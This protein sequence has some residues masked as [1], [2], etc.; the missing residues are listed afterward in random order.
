M[1]DDRRP[2]FIS[3]S[4][5]T[6]IH[7]GDWARWRLP[8]IILK[9]VLL[10]LIVSVLVLQ[11]LWR[12]VHAFEIFGPVYITEAGIEIGL[13]AVFI[14][15]LL[16]NT[17]I[18]PL[19][20]RWHTLRDYSPVILAISIG[21]G[22][23]IG[24]LLCFKF[25]EST[26]GRFLQ[27]VEL[28]MLILFVLVSAFYKMPVR[29]SVVA[30]LVRRR[31][32]AA[33]FRDVEASA[34]G[35][36]RQSQLS[37]V[38]APYSMPTGMGA[39]RDNGSNRQR[40]PSDRPSFTQRISSSSF[41][42]TRIMARRG[43]SG[44]IRGLGN[45]VGNEEGDQRR[46]WN[47]DDPEPGPSPGGQRS[48]RGSL[49]QTPEQTPTAA[50]RDAPGWKDPVLTSVMPDLRAEPSYLAP[51]APKGKDLGSSVPQIV[52][53]DDASQY[54]TDRYSTP[55]IPSTFS[56][57]RN[58]TDSPIYGLDGI[59]RNLQKGGTSSSTEA[60]PDTNVNSNRSSGIESLLRQQQELD[61]S[62]A[63]LRRFSTTSTNRIPLPRT[64][65]E[66]I[67][68]D[69]SLSNFPEPPFFPKSSL[70]DSPTSVAQG[71]LRAIEEDRRS[72]F[73]TEVDRGKSMAISAISDN[74]MIVDDVAFQLVPPRM[75]AV[76]AELGERSQNQSVPTISRESLD[77]VLDDSNPGRTVRLGS[78]GTQYDVTSFIGGLTTPA[79][80]RMSPPL[81]NIS[82]RDR[83]S[84]SDSGSNVPATIADATH[85]QVVDA[86]RPSEESIADSG[87][88][89]DTS[90]RVPLFVPPVPTVSPPEPQD[91]P[92]AESQGQLSQ[93]QGIR[94][95]L[96][97]SGKPL[98]RGRGRGLPTGPRG[99]LE[100]SNPIRRTSSILAEQNTFQR[101]RP[102]P[103]VLLQ[104]A[105]DARPAVPEQPRN[106]GY[107]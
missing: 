64:N 58:E 41:F 74:S 52:V 92:Q 40:A 82:E 62:I 3:L 101:P 83:S 96:L 63:G 99:R 100:I 93:P 46:L 106:G 12:L 69:I 68:S 102:A 45:E 10:L 26:L 95:L 66:S 31:L 91:Q 25:T 65:S 42:G 15:K 50:T 24:N 98:G 57:S 71:G 19:L 22:V 21:M 7:S 55:A 18:C 27:A 1:Q 4:S 86:S 44:Q 8:G 84:G 78:Q 70:L 72:V 16:I 35:D 77:S 32:T 103:L 34:A 33:G 23:A 28:Y 76:I 43:G 49:E 13:S 36:N 59:I 60:L 47:R 37:M 107:F 29:S 17:Y 56:Y 61:R 67:Q 54:T 85:V 81:T 73:E 5:E 97:P 38:Q 6:V 9:W 90:N 80:Q 14:V 39:S 79:A 104:E 48:F 105:N 30:E 88:G 87:I 51:V 20:P 53:P 89:G 75:P 2:N 11:I 94:P